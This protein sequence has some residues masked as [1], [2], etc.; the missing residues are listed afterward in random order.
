M[1]VNNFK[2]CS[3]NCK[4]I[5]YRELAWKTPFILNLFGCAEHVVSQNTL[6]VEKIKIK[7][8]MTYL[9]ITNLD[10]FIFFILET[11]EV[12]IESFKSWTESYT[13]HEHLWIMIGDS[14]P[15][16]SSWKQN[17]P[18]KPKR[19]RKKNQGVRLRTIRSRNMLR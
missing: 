19:T 16:G 10:M 6:S 17:L 7:L 9:N 8:D 1:I 15:Q 18:C 13:K 3:L 4:G 11:K 5:I 2:I 12:V 14:I